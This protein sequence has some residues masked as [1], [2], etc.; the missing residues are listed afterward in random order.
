MKHGIE[1]PQVW[2]DA[3]IEKL[4]LCNPEKKVYLDAYDERSSSISHGMVTKLLG[5]FSYPR[6]C[7]AW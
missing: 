2:I 7:D 3:A 1:I 4:K 5:L 6:M